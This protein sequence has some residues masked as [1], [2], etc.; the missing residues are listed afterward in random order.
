MN[1]K[2]NVVYLAALTLCVAL[3]WAG[4]SAAG[5]FRKSTTPKDT[6]KAA[7]SLDPNLDMTFFTKLQQKS[8]NK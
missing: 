2:R 1:K 8:A 7:E 3:V 6:E 5:H 4:V